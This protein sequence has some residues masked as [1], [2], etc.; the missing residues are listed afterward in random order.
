M[1]IL[2]ILLLDCFI[3]SV[4]YH[5]FSNNNALRNEVGGLISNAADIQDI[6]QGTNSNFIFY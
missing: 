3:L 2:F 1:K 4:H 5:Y 6:H